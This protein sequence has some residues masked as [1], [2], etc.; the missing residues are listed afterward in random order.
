MVIFLAPSHLANSQDISVNTSC[1]SHRVTKSNTHDEENVLL[2]IY[3]IPVEYC[4]EFTLVKVKSMLCPVV[5][6]GHCLHS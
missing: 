6:E 3:C 4:N 1:L 2:V 5:V